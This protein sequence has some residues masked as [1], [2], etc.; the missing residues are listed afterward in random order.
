MISI[1]NDREETK[2]VVFIDL[3][4]SVTPERKADIDTITY[5]CQGITNKTVRVF[6]IM[7]EPMNA[8]WRL[9]KIYRVGANC[10]PY[11]IF[12]TASS[13]KKR[14][15]SLKDAIFTFLVHTL[16]KYME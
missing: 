8:N 14:F 11:S 4:D 10:R 9:F 2:T 7:Y 3:I 13:D 1:K 5:I 12:K 15:L 6:E 16:I